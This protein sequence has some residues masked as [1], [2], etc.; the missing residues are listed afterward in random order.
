[1]FA[2][3]VSAIVLQSLLDV[4]ISIVVYHLVIEQFVYQNRVF[5]GAHILRSPENSVQDMFYVQ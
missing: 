4:R 3:T 2:K 1:M 5:R